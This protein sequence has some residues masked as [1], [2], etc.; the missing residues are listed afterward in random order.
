MP[1]RKQSPI[2]TTAAYH[3]YDRFHRTWSILEPIFPGGSG[4]VGRLARNNRRF[5]NAVFLV[6]HAGPPD[7]TCPVLEYGCGVVPARHPV[8]KGFGNLARPTVPL[9]RCTTRPPSLGADAD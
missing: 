6:P 5:I 7:A 2:T 1:N 3:R 9:F 4:K 8:A